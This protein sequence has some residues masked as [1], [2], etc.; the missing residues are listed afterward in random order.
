MKIVNERL[1]RAQAP[2][3]AKSKQRLLGSKEISV[4]FR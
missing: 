3:C 4:F 2:G 1:S